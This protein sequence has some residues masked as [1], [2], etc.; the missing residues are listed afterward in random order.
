LEVDAHHPD[1]GLVEGGAA[2]TGKLS[3]VGIYDVAQALLPNATYFSAGDHSAQIVG[4]PIL[5]A[6]GFQ[7]AS[8]G[9][10]DS[11]G[12]K[13]PPKR[14]RQAGLPAPQQMQ[15]TAGAKSKWRRHSCLPRPHSWGRSWFDTVS[16]L[17][18][19]G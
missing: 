16:D 18:H 3:L 10:K 8:T 11:R 14:R 1:G 17:R 2:D 9:W 12:A 7:P 6:A 19:S 5:A 13:E 4:Q 15:K